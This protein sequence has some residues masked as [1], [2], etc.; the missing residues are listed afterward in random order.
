MAIPSLMQVGG[1]EWISFVWKHTHQ[2]K[3]MIEIESLWTPL[4]TW[5]H[6]QSIMEL[7]LQ[8]N[9]HHNTL[10]AI[11]QCC[12][13]LQVITIADITTTDGKNL[14]WSSRGQWSAI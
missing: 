9:L 13:F 3:I 11:N 7:T 6:D 12:L 10:Q 2:L 1:M 8:L 4:P 5:Q 14:A